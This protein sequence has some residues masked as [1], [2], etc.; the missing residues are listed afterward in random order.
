MVGLKTADIEGAKRFLTSTEDNY[1]PA[2][3]REVVTRPRQCVFLAQQTT[4]IFYGRANGN[5]RFWVVDLGEQPITKD[6]FE[7]LTDYEVDQIWAEAVS[8]HQV[9]ENLHLSR[10]LEEMAFRIQET[11][12]SMTTG[13]E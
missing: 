7:N 2:Y 12:L 9:G 10:N 3:G 5:R 1:R 4:M 6:L 8:L 13:M 11:I